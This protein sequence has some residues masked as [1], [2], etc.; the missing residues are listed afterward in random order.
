[1]DWADRFAAYV[2]HPRS[3]WPEG[4][5]LQAD[6]LSACAARLAAASSSTLPEIVAQVVAA[7]EQRLRSA[8]ETLFLVN[9][10]SS[11]SHWI[12]AMLAALP[13]VHTCGEVY[14]PTAAALAPPEGIVH[15]PAFLDAVHQLH[16]EDPTRPVLESDLLI[17]SAHSWG[18]HDR[19]GS[20]AR[21]A[22]LV[23]DPLDVVLS[24]TFR[25]PK[26]RRHINPAAHDDEY[27]EQ[28][29]TFVEKFYRA[30]LR[31]KPACVV[32]YEDMR[33]APREHLARLAALVGVRASDSDLSAIA[34]SYSAQ[35][36]TQQ[37]RRTTNLFQGPRSGESPALREWLSGRLAGIRAALGYEPA[38][39]PL[40]AAGGPRR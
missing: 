3:A 30:A 24:R 13:G 35:T 36:Q 4:R 10:G 22:L 34:A 6:K 39:F 16:R 19:M 32:R 28:N 40:D 11:G 38:S 14:L 23:R 18:P 29:A 8:P 17:N 31:R 7:A 26:L 5:T 33:D 15:D 12:E 9:C 25:K 20:T 27:L 21:C 37:G 2:K 1:M